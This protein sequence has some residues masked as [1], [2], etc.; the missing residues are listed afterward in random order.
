MILWGCVVWMVGERGG[1]APTILKQCAT[2]QYFANIMDCEPLQDELFQQAL[3]QFVSMAWDSPQTPSTSHCLENDKLH[4]HQTDWY[5][6]SLPA[7]S[8]S[9]GFI[10]I[11]QSPC[12]FVSAH[13]CM[14]T[15]QLHE[16]VERTCSWIYHK[17]ISPVVLE[18][19][20]IAFFL[21]FASRKMRSI[22]VCNHQ[23]QRH[24]KT[25]TQFP[26]FHVKYARNQWFNCASFHS[27]N[28]IMECT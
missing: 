8:S 18:L 12:Q 25:K 28:P 26:T 23:M 3:Q 13:F 20:A 2:R 1:L 19:V 27:E 6:E 24:K 5:F 11:I 21:A 10:R 7:F 15:T 9:C 16:R 17:W 14:H 22:C 4:N